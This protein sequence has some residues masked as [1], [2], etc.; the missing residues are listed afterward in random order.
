LPEAAPVADTAAATTS[1]PKTMHIML[2]GDARDMGHLADSS[3]HL[4]VTSPPYWT[5]KSYGDAEGQLG[6]IRDYDAFLEE[7]DLVWQECLRVMVPGGRLCI[8]VGDVLLSRK[9]N[10]RHCVMPLHADISTRCMRMGLDYLTPIMWCKISNIKLE[11]STSSRY[12]GRPCEPNGIIKSDLEYIL[13][14]RKPGAYRCPT[15]SMRRTSM[16]DKDDYAN[17]FQQLWTDLPGTSNGQHPATFPE[18]LPYRLIRMFSFS[19]DVV[20]DPFAGVG[21]T[22]LAATRAGRNSISYEVDPKYSRAAERRWARRFGTLFDGAALRSYD[23]QGIGSSA[24]PFESLR[25][26]GRSG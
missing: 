3:V 1:G 11:A 10:G 20:L 9:A 16:I 12:L 22:A 2:R 6:N 17:W 14:F 19:G 8:N 25:I 18:E 21:T 26:V 24:P 23:V 7:L 13:L 4:I 15:D 5:L